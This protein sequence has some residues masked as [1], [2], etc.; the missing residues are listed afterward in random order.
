MDESSSDKENS[1]PNRKARKSNIEEARHEL[2]GVFNDLIRDA[3]S[4]ASHQK[5]G[6]DKQQDQEEDQDDGL[7]HSNAKGGV[8][9]FLVN[10][11]VNIIAADNLKTAQPRGSSSRNAAP[12]GTNAVAR[13][14]KALVEETFLE[15]LERILTLDCKELLLKPI[16]NVLDRIYD[17][18]A[19]Q[20]L[21]VN[22][23][24]NCHILLTKVVNF[25]STMFLLPNINSILQARS[26]FMLT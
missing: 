26:G 22:H 15:F 9:I 7:G 16:F 14:P 10:Q 19:K 24:Q 5:T 13:Y 11:V 3:F 18:M 8:N 6:E 2:N 20:K 25:L 23:K 17:K 4:A 21:L 12:G 1:Q